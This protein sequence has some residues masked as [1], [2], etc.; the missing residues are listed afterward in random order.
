MF[1]NINYSSTKIKSIFTAIAVAA[2][3]IPIF[4]HFKRPKWA[5][6]FDYFLKE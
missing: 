3:L 1:Y 2:I 4:G 6:F 5:D